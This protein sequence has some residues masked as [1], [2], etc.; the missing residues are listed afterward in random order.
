MAL[1][2][3]LLAVQSRVAELASSKQEEIEARQ[4]RRKSLKT[5]QRK[6]ARFGTLTL[7]EEQEREALEIEELSQQ[8]S[9][10]DSETRRATREAFKSS[11]NQ[12]RFCS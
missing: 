7:D 4:Q 5:L 9:L 1:R 2:N 11:R 3:T 10:L 6:M 8:L 12:E